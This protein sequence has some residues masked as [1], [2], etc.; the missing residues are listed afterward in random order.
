MPAT[1]K[2]AIHPFVIV[3]TEPGAVLYTDEPNVY[4]G[5]PFEHHPVCHGAG[6]YVD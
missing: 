2:A 6:V 3:H 1:D 4:R 5:L